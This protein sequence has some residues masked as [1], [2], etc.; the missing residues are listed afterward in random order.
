V[1]TF[2]SNFLGHIYFISRKKC[3]LALFVWWYD[4]RFARFPIRWNRKEEGVHLRERMLQFNEWKKNLFISHSFNICPHLKN[5]FLHFSGI[6][7]VESSYVCIALG[8]ISYS[9]FGGHLVFMDIR[10]T[11]EEGYRAFS[12]SLRIGGV[13]QLHKIPPTLKW[14]YNPTHSTLKEHKN[15]SLVPTHYDLCMLRYV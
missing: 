6:F 13:V 8:E 3:G 15:P 5:P 9:V 1:K 4:P 7:I 11:K 2:C 10:H 12:S 14:A